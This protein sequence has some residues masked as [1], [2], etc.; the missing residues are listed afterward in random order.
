[1]ST[2]LVLLGTGGGPTPKRSRSAPAQAV[3]VGDATYLIDCGNGVGRQLALAGIAFTSLRAI[4]ITHHHSDHNADLGTV[5]QLA[6]GAD[7]ATPVDIYGP[8][9]LAAMMDAF[10]AFA[11]TDIDTRIADEGRPPLRP[12]MRPREVAA[13]GVVHTDDRVRI[14]AARVDHPPMHAYAYRIDSEDRSIVISG[15]TRP[16]R[17]LIDLARGVDVL[18]HEAMHLPSLDL[19]LS[20]TNGSR[21]REHL[22]GSHTSAADAGRVAA[23]AGAKMLVLSHLVPGDAPI[24]DEAWAGEAATEYDGPIV[25]GADLQAL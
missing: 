21:L 3:L 1:M 12:L 9:P 18:V 6:W 10:L 5:L 24:P 23:E 22:L 2:R 14:T 20:R 13:D 15:D 4:A 7:L 25:V 8:P 16:C 19:P 17:S 11:G